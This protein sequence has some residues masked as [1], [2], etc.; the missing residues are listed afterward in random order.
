MLTV[1][2]AR[3]PDAE[4]QEEAK[5]F[6][7]F[8]VHDLD[9][10]FG[11]VLRQCLTCVADLFLSALQLALLLVARRVR[12]H[13]QGVEDRN[14]GH[15]QL[16]SSTSEWY[17]FFARSVNGEAERWIPP[18]KATRKR[19]C[20]KQAKS[21]D[22]G[23]GRIKSLLICY[24]NHCARRDGLNCSQSESWTRTREEW[25]SLPPET[26]AAFVAMHEAELQKEL[27][28]RR[29]RQPRQDILP[30]AAADSCA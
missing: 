19:E 30:Q 1:A 4:R 27:L 9:P 10:G 13:T 29:T 24:H 25:A 16:L 28:E 22:S 23:P 15:R 6:F 11:K 14:A 8:N 17:G 2:D 7:D 12:G 18:S 20:S 3:R 26:Q 5:R 21:S